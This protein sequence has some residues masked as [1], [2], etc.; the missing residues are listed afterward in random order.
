MFPTIPSDL[1][2]HSQ[3]L[4][5]FPQDPAPHQSFPRTL[6]HPVADRRCSESTQRPPLLP[7]QPSTTSAEPSPAQKPW[8]RRVTPDVPPGTPRVAIQG[9]QPTR[10][11]LP[12][13]ILASQHSR[14]LLVLL[15]E[16]RPGYPDRIQKQVS[17]HLVQSGLVNDPHRFQPALEHLTPAPI[18]VVTKQEITPIRTAHDVMPRHCPIDPQRSWHPPSSSESPF[19]WHMDI[20]DPIAPAAG[21]KGFPLSLSRHVDRSAFREFRVIPRGYCVPAL[22]HAGRAQVLAGAR[23]GGG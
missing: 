13:R 1:L 14:P 2:Q 12:S 22:R 18:G 23:C 4:L 15:S 16:P 6:D 21:H 5:L 3:R 10:H 11:K 7:R 20:S 8:H 9:R 19:K 17:P